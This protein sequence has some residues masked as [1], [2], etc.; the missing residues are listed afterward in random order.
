MPPPTDPRWATASRAALAW[1]RRNYPTYSAKHEDFVQD[2]LVARLERG[3]ASP[4]AEDALV[5]AVRDRAR[6]A[7]RTAKRRG[8][9]LSPE[10]AWAEPSDDR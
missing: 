10:Q 9:H 3:D 1:L 7:Y 2:A 5:S 6:A 4:P 8:P